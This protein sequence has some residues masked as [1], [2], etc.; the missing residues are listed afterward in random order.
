MLGV[1]FG[2]KDCRPIALEVPVVSIAGQYHHTVHRM[3]SN[4]QWL[5]PVE[6]STLYVWQAHTVMESSC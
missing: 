2:C 5:T 1:G 4:H 3:L 6:R